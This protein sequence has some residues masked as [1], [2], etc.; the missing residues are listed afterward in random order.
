M[1]TSGTPGARAF[2]LAA[3]VAA[4]GCGEEAR[5]PVAASGD[6]LLEASLAPLNPGGRASLAEYRGQRVIVNFWATW[7]APCREE[8]PD[9]QRLSDALAARGIAVIGVNV[10]ADLN[11]ARE[12]L[13]RHG[14]RFDNFAD[15]GMAYSR[16]AL[17]I[18]AL[19]VTFALDP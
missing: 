1:M 8:M 12:F 2:V 4:A 9:L 11:L 3:L 13:L 5:P 19:P 17:G 16:E 10:D 6:R 14:V 15:A 7:C 18:T